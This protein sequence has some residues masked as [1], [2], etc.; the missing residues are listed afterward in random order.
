MWRNPQ[1]F[2]SVLRL[3]SQKKRRPGS[4]R[5]DEALRHPD[6]QD[7][8]ENASGTSG[9][10]E[11]QNYKNNQE[12]AQQQQNIVEKVSLVLPQRRESQIFYLRVPFL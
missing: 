3:S 2:L 9:I 8:K 4:T 6:L 11:P 12:E 5:L 7:F 10:D 1:V